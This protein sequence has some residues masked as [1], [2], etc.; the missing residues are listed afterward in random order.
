MLEIKS[1]ARGKKNQINIWPELHSASHY[2]IFT[3]FDSIRAVQPQ[4]E[5]IE[6][7]RSVV[8]L[9]HVRNNPNRQS[10]NQG[11]PC[12]RPECPG[13]GDGDRE[14]W[15]TDGPPAGWPS[16]E[17]PAGEWLG[18]GDGRGDLATA[19]TRL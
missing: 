13:T 10:T 8:H 12:L 5:N 4:F 17:A 2:Q 1:E 19:R 18:R 14:R 7:A 9:L 16:R 11:A 15:L 6:R 3:W